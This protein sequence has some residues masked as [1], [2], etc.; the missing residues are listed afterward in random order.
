MR[1]HLKE[2]E[3]RWLLRAETTV[4]FEDPD[5]TNLFAEEEIR[6]ARSA[7]RLLTGPS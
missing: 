2:T 7:W 1:D 3:R 5:L 4:A 6:L